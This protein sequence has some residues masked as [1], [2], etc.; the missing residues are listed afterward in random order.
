MR[1]G[2]RV[3]VTE[4]FGPAKAG[5]LGTV[6]AFSRGADKTAFGVA[7]T[8]GKHAGGD[9]PIVDII[10]IGRCLIPARLLEPVDAPPPRRDRVPLGDEPPPA[11]TVPAPAPPAVDWCERPAPKAAIPKSVWEPKEDGMPGKWSP[12]QHEKYR[13]T[14]EARR[15][16][17]K[18]ANGMASKSRLG[19]APLDGVRDE[20]AAAVAALRRAVTSAAVEGE[21]METVIRLAE[22]VRAVESVAA[23]V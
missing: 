15:N 11:A 21:D 5:T 16:A 23:G 22:A 14:M 1:V 8:G 9:H 13:A 20:L 12:E 3:R 10:D 18:A 7:T 6:V 2:D 19:A 4:S 17:A